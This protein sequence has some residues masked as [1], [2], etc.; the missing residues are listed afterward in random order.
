VKNYYKILGVSRT[1]SSEAIKRAY[2]S[3]A[4]S[5]HPDVYTGKSSKEQFQLINEAYQVLKDEKKRRLYDYRLKQGLY[6]PTVYNQQGRS[7][8]YHSSYARRPHYAY[9]KSGF[10][11]KS[12]KY[13][14]IFDSIIF[15]F[16]VLAGIYAIGFGF[17]RLFYARVEGVDPLKG[18]IAG[19]IFTF[20][21]IFGWLAR[22]R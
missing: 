3:K 17:Y 2:R 5:F 16:M 18:I 13:E 1:A 11:S 7:T 12:Y 8:R 10:D 20:A 22:K 21:I 15:T 19:V 4:K 14:K 9:R 6:R